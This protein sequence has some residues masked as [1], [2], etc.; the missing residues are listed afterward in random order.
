M[1]LHLNMQAN[2]DSAFE[3]IQRQL[4]KGLSLDEIRSSLCLKERP[5]KK[6]FDYKE[7]PMSS[8]NSLSSF[9]HKRHDVC[10]W[11]AKKSLHNNKSNYF[12]PS[13]FLNLVEKTIGGGDNANLRQS[14]NIG[15]NELVVSTNGPFTVFYFPAVQYIFHAAL[16]SQVLLKSVRGECHIVLAVN[17]KG[18]TV[19]HW[20][21]SNMSAGEWLVS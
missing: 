17:L 2:Y 18:A 14:Y 9:H 5:V 16:C 1:R 8:K 11:L 21:V 7:T 15:S 20:G 13:T 4:S 19:L 3:E 6:A 12:H 10:Q